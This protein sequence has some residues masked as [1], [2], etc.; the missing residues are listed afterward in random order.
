MNNGHS[1]R[2]IVAYDGT[3][4]HGWMHNEGVRTVQGVLQQSLAVLTKSNIEVEGASR[5]DTGVHARGYLARVRLDEYLDPV[6]LQRSLQGITPKDIEVISCE[7]ADSD[8]HPRF[9]A[10]G[11]RYLYRISNTPRR[12]LFDERTSWWVRSELDVDAMRTAALPL[13]GRHD[14]AAFRTRSKDEP[15]DTVRSIHEL[16]VDR[17][18]DRVWIQVIGDGFLYRMVRNLVGTLAEVGRGFRE[19]QELASILESKDRSRAGVAAPPQGLFLMEVA[20]RGEELPKASP[21]QFYP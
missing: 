5:T 19:A 3:D 20:C 8:W 21:G 1:Y 18:G 2:L 4:F 17:S 12:P 15:E 14:F 16:T 9:D 10:I 11:K 7:V 13:I 6:E